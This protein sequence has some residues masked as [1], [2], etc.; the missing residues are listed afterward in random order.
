M[1]QALLKKFLLIALL[2]AAIVSIYQGYANAQKIDGSDD[3]QWSPAALFLEGINP[4]THQLDGN[5][6]GR[7]IL[8]QRPNYAHGLYVLLTPLALLEYAKAT[9][10]WAAL[11]IIASLITLL[12]IGREFKLTP[13]SLIICGLLF[14]CSTP[15]RNSIGNGQQSILSLFTFSLLFLQHK[16]IGSFLSGMSYFKYSFAPPIA[17]YIFISRG[18]KA[19]CLSLLPC[20]IGYL[21][22]VWH[23]GADPWTAVIQPLKVGMGARAGWEGVGDVMTIFKMVLPESNSLSRGLLAYLLPILLSC[24][25]ITKAVRNQ[26]SIAF[27]FSVVCVSS[28]MFFSHRWYD[29]IF[30]LPVLAYAI[31]HFKLTGAKVI[32][33][34]VMWNWF[35]MKILRYFLETNSLGFDAN[36]YLISLNFFLNTTLLISLFNINNHLAIHA[37]RVPSRLVG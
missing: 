6:D 21:L 7:I 32:A 8:S 11:G 3:F 23:L 18:W 10:A 1:N 24:W 14:F 2:L 13:M 12:L 20:L 33:V 30:L 31:A 35:A 28:L 34:I 17:F 25:V 15:F 16:N 36:L 27:S 5:A 26:T 19:V 4:Y 22:F 37:G 9:A 29:H